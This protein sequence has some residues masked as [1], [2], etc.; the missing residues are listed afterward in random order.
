MDAPRFTPCRSFD[1]YI[2]FCRE[3]E[4]EATEIAAR[5]L[6]SLL[7]WQVSSGGKDA[8]FFEK[9]KALGIKIDLLGGPQSSLR[10]LEQGE[11][12]ILRGRMQF[13]KAQIW[14]RA[15]KLCLSAVTRHAYS[16]TGATLCQDT[17]HHL[18]VFVECLQ[19]AKPRVITHR[20]D[21][22]VFLFTDA[23]FHP[24][25]KSWPCG[26]GG[27]LVDQFGNQISAFST[28]LNE[29]DLKRLGYPCKST[30]I[31]EAELL[32]VIV[33]LKLWHKAKSNHPCV[34]FVDNNAARDVAISGSARSYPGVD[35]AATLLVIEDK[36]SLTNW[37]SRAP[38]TSNIADGPSRNDMTGIKVKLTSNVLARLVLD[39]IFS[40]FRGQYG[41]DATPDSVTN[42]N[43]Y[44]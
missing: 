26:L 33:C 1:D 28:C 38:S 29:A 19:A 9:F 14:G 5:Q 43:K 11:A 44:G 36:L 6:F 2:T 34:V 31:F 7:G 40:Q 22:P 41:G 30:V 21:K 17:M 35:L 4:V 37:Y 32:A 16:S 23:S 15:A 10:A 25:D 27:I 13:A 8:P 39:K 24:Q 12:L 42:D 3:S 20:W 18:K